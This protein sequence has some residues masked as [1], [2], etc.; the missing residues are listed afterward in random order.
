MHF[1]VKELSGAATIVRRVDN[2]LR[3]EV[4]DFF[5]P[6]EL[7]TLVVEGSLVYWN[8]ATGETFVVGSQPLSAV[9]PAAEVVPEPAAAVEPAAVEPAPKAE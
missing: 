8:D 6:E 1:R 3:L 9:E 7:E 2:K 5:Y 4:G